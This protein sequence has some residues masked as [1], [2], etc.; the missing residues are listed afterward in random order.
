M[1][2]FLQAFN[3]S[4]IRQ[5]LEV[6]VYGYQVIRYFFK[7]VRHQSA[8]KTLLFLCTT[9]SMGDLKTEIITTYYLPPLDMV[10]VSPVLVVAH[11]LAA[12]A[13]QPLHTQGQE[14]QLSAGVESEP[15]P[16]LVLSLLYQCT[17]TITT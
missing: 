5:L 2:V 13:L 10:Q 11:L 15:S 9:G 12:V 7:T 8:K 4:G 1:V 14:P 16:R 6:H 3:T 17:V